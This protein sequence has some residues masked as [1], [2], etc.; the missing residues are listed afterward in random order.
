MI[1]IIELE[2]RNIGL[3]DRDHRA[4]GAILDD[5]STEMSSMEQAALAD[6]SGSRPGVDWWLVGQGANRRPAGRMPLVGL[7]IVGRLADSRDMAKSTS[8]ARPKK[9]AESPAAESLL[10]DAIPMPPAQGAP[11]APS[12]FTPRSRP[13]K[14][15]RPPATDQQVRDAGDVARELEEP[16]YADDFG[17]RAPNQPQI[18]ASLRRFKGWATEATRAAQWLAYAQAQESA[19]WQDAATRMLALQPKFEDA[20]RDEPAIAERYPQTDAFLH[21]HK[22]A[23]AKGA[24][25]RAAKKKPKKDAPK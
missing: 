3:D 11:A 21:V 16:T 7:A 6:E 1:Q 9:P 19:A 17:K 13:Q 2:G 20:V 15:D 18:V 8:V 14:G 24:A 22:V 4:R 12:G 23:A 25:T 10:K 5:E